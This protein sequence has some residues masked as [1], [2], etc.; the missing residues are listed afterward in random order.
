[1]MGS[2]TIYSSI[3]ND[4]IDVYNKRMSEVNMPPDEN[5]YLSFDENDP[6]LVLEGQLDKEVKK[7]HKSMAVKSKEV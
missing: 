4:L 2:N 1:M 7:F 5:S 6:V 3:A